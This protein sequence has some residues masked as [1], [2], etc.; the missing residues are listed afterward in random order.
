LNKKR[1]VYVGE[2]GRRIRVGMLHNTAKGQFMI[3]S[4]KKIILVEFKVFDTRS[5]SFFLEEELCKI[6]IIKT[7]QGFEYSFGIDTEVETPLNE[8]RKAIRKSDRKKSI[9]AIAGVLTLVA[10]LIGGS[11]MLHRHFLEQERIKNGAFSAGIVHLTPTTYSYSLSY[12]FGTKHRT[13][14]RQIE[15]YRTPN[16]KSSNG[17]PL[18][19][20][21]EFYVQYAR[22]NPS[23]N[24]ILF[25]R[26]TEK[27]V[28]VYKQRSLQNHMNYNP[29]QDTL[30]C[31]C[32][33]DAA[34]DLKGLSG[35]AY[36]YYQHLPPSKNSKYNLKTYNEFIISKE[37][38][39][40]AGDCRA[41]L[42]Q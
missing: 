28:K 4:G 20:S 5:F 35:Y 41:A 40:K 38:E 3:Y 25:N 7:N 10:L 31:A 2:N 16:P 13:Y 36:F 6:N 1:W 33:L 26:P 18:Y 17:F 22:T 11:F 42:E 27:Q 9:L 37:F 12:S 23:N 15:Y 14:S 19:D 24:V 8:E 30:Y 39:E 34:Y 32:L 29:K 21:D